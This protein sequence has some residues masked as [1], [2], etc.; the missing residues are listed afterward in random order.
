MNLSG[1]LKNRSRKTVQDILVRLKQT[2]TYRAKG[3]VKLASVVIG[4]ARHA[5]KVNAGE[6]RDIFL[7]V[8]L[9]SSLTPTINNCTI[10]TIAYTIIIVAETGGWCDYIGVD[11]PIV[12]G[13]ASSMAQ[14][15]D[16][17]GLTER[18]DINSALLVP[19]MAP[20]ALAHDAHSLEHPL[21][22][23]YDS[24]RVPPSYDLHG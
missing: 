9:E 19:A 18:G 16:A 1:V 20:L 13:T 11:L 7:K 6:T 12:I 4:S 15:R 3:R 2:V 17:L 21:A 5:F 23:A 14:S 10:I 8:P 22:P 24:V